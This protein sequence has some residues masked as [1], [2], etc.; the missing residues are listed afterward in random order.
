MI[1]IRK[2]QNQ[3][4]F[5]H[6]SFI[7]GKK[8]LIAKIKRKNK[9]INYQMINTVVPLQESGQLVSAS[10]NIQQDT[11]LINFYN[12]ENTKKITKNSLGKDLNI[13]IGAI[14]SSIEK[15]NILERKIDVLS[16]QNQDFLLQN[17]QMLQELL[18]KSEYNKKLEAAICI[19]LEFMMNKNG[20]GKKLCGDIKKTLLSNE[21]LFSNNNLFKVCKIN[22]IT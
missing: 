8:E 16:N 12:P 3:H 19:I 9:K 7:R 6:E 21:P 22:F 18:T 5:Q 10:Q 4:I 17:Q 13:L 14:N 11:N 2:K 15:Q 1:S 20:P